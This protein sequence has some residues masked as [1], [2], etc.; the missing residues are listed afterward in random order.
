MKKTYQTLFGNLKG[1]C[2]TACI[3]TILE[4]PIESIPHFCK[5]G[6]DNWYA[7]F[8]WWLETVGYSNIELLA[9]H[10]EHWS[11][12]EG[13]QCYL[14]GKSPRGNFDHVV[15]GRYENGEYKIIFD[16]HP[17]NTGLDGPLKNVGFFV[18]LDPCNISP[19]T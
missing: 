10:Y 18:P 19:L 1:N 13:L 15:V 8:L 5:G 3:S 11:P 17:D 4:I 2:F 14:S 12:S 6:N 16:P 9:E 7:D